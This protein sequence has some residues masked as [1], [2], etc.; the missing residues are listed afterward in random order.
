MIALIK[1]RLEIESIFSFQARWREELVVTG[2]G[3][4]FVLELTMGVL[5]AYLPTEAAWRLNAPEW[6]TD[7]WPTLKA[8]LE[9]WCADS[10]TSTFALGQH[11]ISNCA[12]PAL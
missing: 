1:R 8:E 6:A 2:P 9:D 7:L 11:P 10:K 4:G 3:G 5:T 12:L